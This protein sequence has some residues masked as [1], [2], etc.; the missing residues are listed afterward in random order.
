VVLRHRARRIAAQLAPRGY[1]MTLYNLTDDPAQ[2][3]SLFET[4]LRRRRVDGLIVLS[5]ELSAD[6][7]RQLNE[8]PVP[9]VALGVPHAELRGCASTTRPWAGGHAAPA[10]TRPPRH[11][12]PRLESAGRCGRDP[13]H[14]HAPAPR[15]RAGDEDA[16]VA[17]PRFVTADFT[18]EGR[19]AYRELLSGPDAPTAIF[20]ASDEMAFGVLAAARELG[21]EVPGRLSVIGVDG[22]ELAEL[23][24]LTTIEQFPHAQGERAGQTILAELGVDERRLPRHPCRSSSWSAAPPRR[25]TDHRFAPPALPTRIQS[26][27]RP[28]RP[29]RGNTRTTPD[30]GT[31]QTEYGTG[32][33]RDAETRRAATRREQSGDAARAVPATRREQSRRRGGNGR[34]ARSATAE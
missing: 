13:R 33:C 23:F 4:S 26:A 5:V 12:A 29:C 20:A 27:L 16:G 22:H 11:R 7:L 3:R 19:A 18:V 10:G 1:D 24:E 28:R 2:R 17:A 14:P 9:V 15:I 6:E 25:R 21:I 32:R 30:A 8:L 34:S 31:G